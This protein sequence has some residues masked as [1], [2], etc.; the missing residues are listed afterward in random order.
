[1]KK[2]LI[3]VGAF[4]VVIF[5][6]A[7]LILPSCTSKKPEPKAEEFIGYQT[8]REWTIGASGIGMEILVSPTNTKE[9]IMALAGH[10]RKEKI[11]SG[12][13]N[14]VFIFDSRDAWAN[15]ENDNYPQ[16]KYMKHFLVS[17]NVPATGR[18]EIRWEAE[19][20]DE[21]QKQQ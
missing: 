4:V 1:M 10:L 16:E 8:L 13:R 9:E 7:F 5:L 2:F 14:I 15:R 18:P 11:R 21:P 17:I 20:R 19:G 12:T 6:L 3:G